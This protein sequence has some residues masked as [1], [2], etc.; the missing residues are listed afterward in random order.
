MPDDKFVEVFRIKPDDHA[1][2]LSVANATLLRRFGFVELPDGGW[3]CSGRT[4]DA[5]ANT[6][7][8][9]SFGWEFDDEG[10]PTFD[11]D[12]LASPPKCLAAEGPADQLI[13]AERLEVEAFGDENGLTPER[14]L[15]A[16][17]RGVYRDAG[18][19]QEDLAARVGVSQSTVSDWVNGRSVPSAIQIVAIDEACGHPAGYTMTAARLL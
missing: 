5:V 17:I 7:R 15:G 8:A 10:S 1:W 6:V 13:N 14:Q 18:I 19:R 3:A 16:V 2:A 11:E 12:I 9:M 4:G